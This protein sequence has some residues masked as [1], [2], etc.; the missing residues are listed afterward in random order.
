MAST[1]PY[2]VTKYAGPKVA[3]QPAGAGDVLQ[4]TQAQASAELLAGAIVKGGKGDTA[5]KDADPLKGSEKL[6]DLRA[7]AVGLDKAPKAETNDTAP[8]KASGDAKPQAGA[9]SKPAPNASGSAASDAKP[10][11]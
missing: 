1:E 9:A 7:R 8:E 6:D 11:T 2:T 4:L 10:A 3:G 5:A